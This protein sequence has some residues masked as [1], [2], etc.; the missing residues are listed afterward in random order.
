MPTDLALSRASSLPQGIAGERG[1]AISREHCGSELARD[2][3]E[4][5]TSM[6]T[7][8]ALPRASSLPQGIAGERGFAIS[9]EHYGSELARDCGESVTSMPTDLALSRASSLP[10]GLCVALAINYMAYQLKYQ[11]PYLSNPEASIP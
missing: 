11:K 6:P 2:C 10:Q 1:F 4:P 3:G 9:R 7:D 8:L 5:V